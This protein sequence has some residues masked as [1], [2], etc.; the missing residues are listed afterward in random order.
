MYYVVRSNTWPPPVL[1]W[2]LL[3][4]VMN[5][6]LIY[7]YS[8]CN[9]QEGDQDN[10]LRTN[11][12]YRS[13]AQRIFIDLRFTARDCNSFPGV[14]GACKE[15]FNLYYAESEVDYGTNF[16]KRLFRKIDTIAPD[17][18]TNRDDFS[19]RNVRLN[20]EVRNVGPMTKKGFYLAFQDI[21]ACLALLGVRIY[22]KKCPA[23]VQGMAQ[24]PETVASAD[25]QTLV[26]DN[27]GE[28]SP[29]QLVGMLRGIA[30]GMKYLSEMNY[31]HRDLAARNILV[32]SQLVCKVSD[33]GLSRVLEDDPEATYTTS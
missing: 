22:Y 31:V 1:Q 27:D 30:A 32:N 19:S 2:D 9:V 15:T 26:K 21:G 13:E 3:Q 18:I 14:S 12:I 16:Q 20:V 28:F 10:W 33:F 17:E 4:N 24:F 29:I 11:W 5:G 7:M 25:S 8:V 6:S 23:M